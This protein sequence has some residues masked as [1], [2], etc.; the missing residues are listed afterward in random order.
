MRRAGGS[1]AEVN[2]YM[3]ERLAWVRRAIEGLDWL[4]DMRQQ[5]VDAL[6]TTLGGEV[7]RGVF[8]RSGTNVGDLPQFSGAG[9]NLTVPNQTSVADVLASVKRVWTSPFSERAFLWRRQILVEQGD[10]YPLVLL[11]ESVPSEKSGVLITSGLQEGRPED[12]TVVT[13]EGVG[14]AV[15]GAVGMQ[16]GRVGGRRGGDGS[17]PEPRSKRTA[18]IRAHDGW[19]AP[20]TT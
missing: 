3:L 14:G 1:D 7:E 12:L 6:T 18:G 15:D 13:A 10:V 19:W 5:V 16:R 4:P 8:V 20:G 2:A 11:L 17:G 9:L